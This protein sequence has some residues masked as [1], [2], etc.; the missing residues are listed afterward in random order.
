MSER[1]PSRVVSAGHACEVLNEFVRIV[2]GAGRFVL[3]EEAEEGE[4]SEP[5]KK[6]EL[7][8]ARVRT[9]VTDT[10]RKLLSVQDGKFDSMGM[11][12]TEVEGRVGALKEGCCDADEARV[13]EIIRDAIS[14]L[15]QSQGRVVT[16][17]EKRLG[18]R[19][20]SLTERID[21]LV[22]GGLDNDEAI[23]ELTRRANGVEMRISAMAG[24][25]KD[26]GIDVF[27]PFVS[28]VEDGDTLEDAC[29]YAT[30]DKLVWHSWARQGRWVL[31]KSD[32][33]YNLVEGSARAMIYRVWDGVDPTYSWKS[34]YAFLAWCSSARRFESGGFRQFSTLALAQ[35]WVEDEVCYRTEV[36][37]NDGVKDGVVYEG[38]A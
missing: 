14:P 38:Q 13:R 30:S 10:M 26:L 33:N 7:D 29:D 28:E 8:E 23:E 27:G 3:A 1:Y 2:G 21:A 6:F 9:I 18:E 15:L 16:G 11:R 37:L 4:M 25:L 34:E 20:D 31:G 35:C 12:L 36:K 22:D 32:R 5:V 24:R 19:V 17:R